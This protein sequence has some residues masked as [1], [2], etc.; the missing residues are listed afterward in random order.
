MKSALERLAEAIGMPAEQLRECARAIRN[1]RLNKKNP[2][3]CDH[4]WRMSWPLDPVEYTCQKCCQKT[5]S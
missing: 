3:D 2:G 5:L 4:D 1:K